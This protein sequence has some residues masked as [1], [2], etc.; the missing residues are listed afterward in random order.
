MGDPEVALHVALRVKTD[1]WWALGGKMTKK[2][3]DYQTK[4]N[5]KKTSGRAE[6]PQ[7]DRLIIPVSSTKCL[8]LEQN[9]VFRSWAV[10]KG[11][12]S[13]RRMNDSPP[14]WKITHSTMVISSAIQFTN[15]AQRCRPNRSPAR[16]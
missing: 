6:R 11:H 16:R 15:G 12:L 2:L 4:R 13:I 5:F 8:R 7:S 9:G 10:T 14:R 3:T 1:R